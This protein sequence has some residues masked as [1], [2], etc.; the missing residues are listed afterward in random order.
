MTAIRVVTDHGE[1]D[2]SGQI[3]HVDLDNYVNT[4]PW[5]VV[6]GST[7][8]IPPGARKLKAGS[9]ITI[10]DAGPGGNL[11]IS[12]TG[13]G[14]GTTSVIA[15]SEI[16]AG[17][18]DGVNTV[19]SISNIPDPTTALM[20]FVNGVL[21]RQGALNDYS[22]SGT[23]IQFNWAPQSASNVIAT[24]P[25]TIGVSSSIAWMEQPS[26]VADGANMIFT[27]SN[28][29]LSSSLMFFVNG[30][31]Q[32]QGLINDFVLFGS[33]ITMN[34]APFAGSNL[35]ATYPF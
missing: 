13:G 12:S 3:S 27:L 32:S 31:L 25:Y 16:P 33:Q 28:V 14:S 9:G 2:N 21:Q 15:W 8:A 4:T 10:V 18:A 11:T 24:Y 19:F 23:S 6:T 7:G 29:P 22:L 20:L 26:G 34:Y 5:L 30:V 1:L 35:F 17:T